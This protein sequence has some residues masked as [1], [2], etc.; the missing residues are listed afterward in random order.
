M[1]VH[2]IKMNGAVIDCVGT[3]EPS[4]EYAYYYN[5]TALSGLKKQRV[6]YIKTNYN[7][8]FFNILDGVY[9]NLKAYIRAHKGEPILFGFPDGN[10]YVEREY[11]CTILSEINK[12]YL[13]NNYYKN[14][15]KVSFEA[16]LPDE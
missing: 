6:R 12:G 11:Y 4:F 15:L 5:E 14:G 9:D 10:G 16:V 7:A 1:K 3:I 13:R 8:Q 2:S